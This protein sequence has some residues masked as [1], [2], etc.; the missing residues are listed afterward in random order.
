M[1][2]YCGNFTILYREKQYNVSRGFSAT[3]QREIAWPV[4]CAIIR[5]KV[6]YFDTMNKGV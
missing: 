6:R 3:G 1:L 5:A 4:I 2:V